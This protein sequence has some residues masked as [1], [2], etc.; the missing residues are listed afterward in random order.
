[1]LKINLNFIL[2]Q[3]KNCIF[4]F[5]FWLKLILIISFIFLVQQVDTASNKDSLVLLY[6]NG[7]EYAEDLINSL[8]ASNY[9]GF[10]FEK[11]ASL[12]STK[13][14]VQKNYA[15]CGLV[16]NRDFDF[17]IE[18]GNLSNSVIFYQSA[19]SID[20]YAVKEVIF[21]YILEAASNTLIKNY[22]VNNSPRTD[23]ISLIYIAN[24]ND[25]I[26]RGLDISIFKLEEG[27]SK[28]KGSRSLEPFLPYTIALWLI[29]A[30]SMIDVYS[31][32]EQLKTYLFARRRLHR[33][34]FT[35][36]ASLISTCII[37]T[38]VGLFFFT[39]KTL[40]FLL[41]GI[42]CTVYSYILKMFIRSNRAYSAII[43]I[44]LLLCLLI[45]P[46][47]Y[48]FSLI[49]P[50]IGYIAKLIPLSYFVY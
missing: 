48:D 34:I 49:I 17:A 15:V 14:A 32:F 12:S 45:C 23:E 24:Y 4:N 38:L 47:I 29:F 13:N 40:L 39:D 30:V 8:L 16:F 26:K 2:L 25:S 3:F 44:L 7:S 5:F 9:D 50:G 1:M 18:S 20:G 10:R 36:E 43:P 19:A 33:F 31:I 41:Y 27:V 42:C 11:A 21:P 6:N 35:F 37:S 46:V 22:I 28:R